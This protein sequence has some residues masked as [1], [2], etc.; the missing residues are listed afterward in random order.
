MPITQFNQLDQRAGEVFGMNECNAGTAPAHLGHLIDQPGAVGSEMLEGCIDVGHREGDVM[1]PLPIA[2][3]ESADGRVRRQ[4]HEELNERSTHREH[5]LL[6]PLSL[7]DLAIERLDPVA[8]PVRRQGRIEV[9]N[10]DSNM[11][12]IEQLHSK[13]EDTTV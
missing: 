10:S 4:W 12:Q 13:A 3:D 6:H 8:F 2:L 7:D 9:D 5:R 11:I 1:H